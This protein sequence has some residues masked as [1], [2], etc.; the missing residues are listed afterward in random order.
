VFTKSA[1]YYDALYAWKDYPK[2]VRRL[3]AVIRSRVPDAQ[4]LLDVACGTGKHLDLLR[5]RYRVEGSDLDP[6]FLAIARDRVPGVPL[7]QG[8]MR[9][10]DLGRR[11]DVVTCLFS[12]IGYARGREELHRAIGA[13]AR[14]LSPEG[15]VVVEPW[16]T[17]EAWL[18]GHVH[19]LFVDRP[20][21]KIVRMNRSDREGDVAVMD[22]HYLV[23]TPQDGVHHFT[24]RHELT[25]FS[26]ED[27]LE[28]FL[29]AGLDV[30][31]DPKGLMSRGLYL[32][33][34]HA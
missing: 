26:C 9:D 28:A 24:E 32:G 33:L 12:S 34:S 2:E 25:L 30:G 17:A 11:F 27:Y 13:M 21:L 3:D 6:Q 15:L 14:H 31:Y 7:H 23:A 20:D 19:A 18:V 5:D 8:D 22:M 16:F 4:T 29:A 10:F 1:P